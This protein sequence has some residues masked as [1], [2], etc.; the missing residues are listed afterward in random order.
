MSSRVGFFHLYKLRILSASKNTRRRTRRTRLQKPPNL[1]PPNPI[2]LLVS[3]LFFCFPA[4][5]VVFVFIC[6]R[7]D[8]S[9]SQPLEQ[10][11]LVFSSDKNKFHRNHSTPTPGILQLCMYVPY[12]R[13][14][15][16]YHKPT[17]DHVISVILY[18]FRCCFSLR[19]SGAYFVE[20]ELN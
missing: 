5:F 7:R 19:F 13:L 9:K 1:I 16:M 11:T 12:M 15:Y 17:A 8:F 20:A 6:F 10:E 3:T 2:H 4:R 18:S 14:F